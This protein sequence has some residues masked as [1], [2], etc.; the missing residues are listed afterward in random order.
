M[1]RQGDKIIL[2]VEDDEDMLAAFLGVLD[3]SGYAA[4][5]A[6]HGQQAL[7]KLAGGLRP[8]LIVLDLMMPVM[9]GWELDEKLAADPV[10]SSIP[11]VFVSAGGVPRPTTRTST[12]LKKPVPLAVLLKAIRAH[13]A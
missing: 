5:G 3:A 9:T 4:T 8:C 13:C 6:C 1:S 2:V 10:L 11:V 7:D 12:Y